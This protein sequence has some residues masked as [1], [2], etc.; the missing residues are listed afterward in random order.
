MHILE[1]NQKSHSVEAKRMRTKAKKNARWRLQYKG[2]GRE[3]SKVHILEN[4]KVGF[5]LFF[6]YKNVRFDIGF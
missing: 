5:T 6:T 2:L 4:I 1:S 3:R